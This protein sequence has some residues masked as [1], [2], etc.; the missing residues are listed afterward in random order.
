VIKESASWSAW[1]RVVL[2]SPA[3]EDGADLGC[4]L[5]RPLGDIGPVVAQ[6]DDAHAGQGV[7]PVDIT[8]SILDPVRSLPVEFD[9]NAEVSV[10][11]VQVTATPTENQPRLTAGDGQAVSA[12]DTPDIAILEIGV[13]AFR[14]RRQCGED[15]ASVTVLLA[16][17]Q[18]FPEATSGGKPAAAR[19]A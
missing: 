17:A 10:Q 14:D 16:L 7:V 1:T 4:H 2:P 8:P 5:A 15:L 9:G 11:I 18:R 19:L 6:C 3:A 12:L 13:H